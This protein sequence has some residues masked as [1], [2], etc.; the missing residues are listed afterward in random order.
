MIG[1]PCRQIPTALSRQPSK[2]FLQPPSCDLSCGMNPPDPKPTKPTPPC[3]EPPGAAT[4][5]SSVAGAARRD[6]KSRPTVAAC[7]VGLDGTSHPNA[8]PDRRHRI[9]SR[10]GYLPSCPRTHTRARV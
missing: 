2:T 5:T 3:L 9:H 4:P 8:E 7:S 10:D 6:G 1:T